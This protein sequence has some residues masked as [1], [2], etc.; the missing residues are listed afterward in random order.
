MFDSLVKGYSRRQRGALLVSGSLLS[1]AWPR[2]QQGVILL[3]LREYIDLAPLFPE[4]L[5]PRL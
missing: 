1:I 5:N 4:T 2:E 3:S